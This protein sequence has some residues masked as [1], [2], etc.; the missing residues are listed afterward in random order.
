MT[1][2]P[3]TTSDLTDV[4]LKMAHQWCVYEHHLHNPDD[5]SASLIFI[6]WC[7]LTDAYT[8]ADAARNSEWA[9]LVKPSSWLTVRIIQTGNEIDCRNHAMAHMRA[10][11]PMPICNLK[12]IDTTL[13]A[14]RIGCSNG[15]EY[16][17]Q[18]AAAKALGIPQG[19]LSRH[20]KGDLKHVKGLTFWRIPPT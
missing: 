12:G 11:Q 20:L 16:E 4:A 13:I 14:R 19:M 9:R 8:L 1:L 5:G 7:K 6:S 18:T 17:T 3:Q 2:I 15:Q 10:L